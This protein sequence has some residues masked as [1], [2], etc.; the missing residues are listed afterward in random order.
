MPQFDLN[1]FS[2]GNSHTL[3]TPYI[4]SNLSPCDK[5]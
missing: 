4:P 2:E 3:N 1:D 5:T